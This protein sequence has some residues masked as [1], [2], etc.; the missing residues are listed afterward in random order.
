MLSSIR[1]DIML[2]FERHRSTQVVWDAVK[3]M[4]GETF[5]IR[6]R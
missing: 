4:Y 2:Y 1:N 3:I 6:F 5:T